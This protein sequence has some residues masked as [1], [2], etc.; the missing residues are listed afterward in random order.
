[1]RCSGHS[2]V[3]SNTTLMFGAH[4][5]ESHELCLN[6][7]VNWQKLLPVF[8]RTATVPRILLSAFCCCGKT[9]H[10]GNLRWSVFRLPVAEGQGPAWRQE[11]Q[12][13]SLHLEIKHKEHLERGIL[14]C[15][16]DILPPTKPD[17][18]PPL[19][20]TTNWGRVL[21]VKS[22]WGHSY[23]TTTTI[24]LRVLSHI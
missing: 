13:E 4:L 17:P 20:S 3:P 8:T 2:R 9:H 15:L 14:A 6:V 1:M 11:Q 16:H 10:Q 7:R 18:H 22:L 19:N 23:S 12:A 5:W 21:D 24:A